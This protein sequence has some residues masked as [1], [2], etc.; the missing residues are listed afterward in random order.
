MASKN[1][2]LSI[3]IVSYNTRKITHQCLESIYKSF[4]SYK[5]KDAPTFEIVLI[6]NASTKDDS[7]TYLTDYAKKHKNIQFVANGTNTGFGPAN[8]QGVKLAKGT[9]TLLLNSDTIVLKDAIHK[10]FSFYKKNENTKHFV[11]PKLFNK[12]MTPQ[13]S[14]A[15]FYSLPIIFGALFL[16]GDYWG[17]T[18]YSPK[19]LRKV[20]WVSGA[21]IMTQKK[22]FEKVGGFDET[23]FMYMEEV[24]LLYRAK[25]MQ[26]NTYYYPKSRLVHL[27]AA[28]SNGKTFPI[29]QVYRGFLFFYKK[30]HS[31]LALFFLRFL[32]RLKAALAWF[33]G[34]IINNNYL[35][36]TYE[37]AFKVAGQ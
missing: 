25:K 11:G 26:M 1:P 37:E 21:C 2:D 22:Y 4:R 20:D 16:R 29:L 19:I 17:L 31:R 33:L 28:S 35:K 7:V 24:D 30:H 10:L 9:Y 34:F 36:H 27:G 18:R 13:P 14:A 3:V 32:L 23:I 6:D 12:D 8:N 5:S 15:S